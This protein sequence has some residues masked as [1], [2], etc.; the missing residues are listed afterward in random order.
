M[1]KINAIFVKY[2]YPPFPIGVM[3]FIWFFG[4]YALYVSFSLPD[5]FENYWFWPIPIWFVIFYITVKYFDYMRPRRIRQ[6]I[7][8]FNQSSNSTGR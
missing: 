1:Q 2:G 8:K 7:K 5:W 4:Y 3:P 6:E